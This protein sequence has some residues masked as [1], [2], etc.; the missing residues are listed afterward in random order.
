MESDRELAASS[1]LGIPRYEVWKVEPARD[2][3]VAGFPPDTRGCRN[4]GEGDCVSENF[5]EL[6]DLRLFERGCLWKHQ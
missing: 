6:T 2:D 3:I 1:K 4:G 5:T